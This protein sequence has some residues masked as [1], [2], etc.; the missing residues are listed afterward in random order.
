MD[1]SYN[2]EAS[3]GIAYDDPILGINWGL[4]RTPILSDQ[5]KTFPIIKRAEIFE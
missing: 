4:T 1:N 3:R 2:N 5:D